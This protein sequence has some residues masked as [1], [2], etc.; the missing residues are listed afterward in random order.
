MKN[1]GLC[2]VDI[3]PDP[4]GLFVLMPFSE[5][6]APQKL[7]TDLLANLSG[8]R[9]SRADRD[10]T[11]PEIV[12][13][14]CANIQGSR[15]VIVDLSG[16]NANVFLELGLAWGVGTPFI[17]LTQDYE[18]LPFDTKSFQ[19]I[20]YK[21]QASNPSEVANR[22]AVIAEINAALT[23]L[24]EPASKV[25]PTTREARLYQKVQKAKSD[26]ARLWR[27]ADDQW[28]I[29]DVA[30]VGTRIGLSL[31]HSYPN[32]KKTSL[33]SVEASVSA[34]TINRYVSGNIGR[35]SEYF[36]RTQDGLKL[37]DSGLYWLIEEAIPDLMAGI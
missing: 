23:S 34:S 11:K 4:W 15:A 32:A 2:N 9:V 6:F 28:K 30:D 26:A 24:P 27:I 36:G 16:L 29:I 22:D 37:T 31:L 13:K 21:R 12:C 17:L 3:K 7:Y 14:I 33:A 8:W 10:L 5:D 19:T 35:H 20:R 1:Y 18:E 25:A